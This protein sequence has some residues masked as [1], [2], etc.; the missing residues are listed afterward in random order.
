M[1][2]IKLQVANISLSIKSQCCMSH[3]PLL[4]R[5]LLEVSWNEDLTETLQGASKR[6]V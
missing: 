6:E 4:V 3:N 5:K 2:S 1:S